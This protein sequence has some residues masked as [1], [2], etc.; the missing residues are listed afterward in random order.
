LQIVDIHHLSDYPKYLLGWA[1][2]VL[3]LST[4]ACTLSI[5]YKKWKVDDGIR[6]V[7][8][9]FNEKQKTSDSRNEDDEESNEP[10]Y[11]ED[12]DQLE[13]EQEAE[14]GEITTTNQIFR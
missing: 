1:I 12:K 5:I 2:R 13:E 6:F 7:S 9:R 11:D 4:T 3:I 10:D 8:N 14:A